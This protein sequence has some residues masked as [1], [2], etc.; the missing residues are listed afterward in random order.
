MWRQA[1][2]RN[3]QPRVHRRMLQ[4]QDCGAMDNCPS[5]FVR[6]YARNIYDDDL[7][8]LEHDLVNVNMLLANYHPDDFPIL[9]RAFRGGGGADRGENRNRQDRT[10]PDRPEDRFRPSRT[11]FAGG[12]RKVLLPHRRTLAGGLLE[13]LR[14]RVNRR[15]GY[16]TG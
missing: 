10:K 9:I 6:C 7:A 2:V 8:D 13:G 5:P 16:C 15:L 11:A 14:P 4:I 12:E 1:H 3:R